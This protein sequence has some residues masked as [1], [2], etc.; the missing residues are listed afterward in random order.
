MSK[1][2]LLAILA[3]CFAPLQAGWF[4]NIRWDWQALIYPQK[5]PGVQV[6]RNV[7]E[8]TI[9]PA[10]EQGKEIVRKGQKISADAVDV[11]QVTL[12]L[13]QSI[14]DKIKMVNDGSLKINQIIAD[15]QNQPM[16]APTLESLQEFQADIAAQ[17]VR[18]NQLMLL[19]LQMFEEFAKTGSLAGRVI[20]SFGVLLDDIGVQD[21]ARN[22]QQV[23]QRAYELE[24]VA[25]SLPA[26][27]KAVDEFLTGFSKRIIGE[28][29]KLTYVIRTVDRMRK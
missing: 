25:Q 26:K 8:Q 15:L 23:A 22:T 12:P 27:L 6:M 10:W 17:M 14:K 18:M 16:R 11:V 20:E 29:E 28:V 2:A 7:N 9:Q 24:A 13:I 5:S 3:V 19:V 4:D 21:A 1:P